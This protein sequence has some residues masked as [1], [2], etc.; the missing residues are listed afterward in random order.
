MEKH[1]WNNVLEIKNLNLYIRKK[2]L[3]KNI[4]LSIDNN[5][6]IGIIGYSKS[7][8]SLLLKCISK[9]V[10]LI[11]GCKIE[12]TIEINGKNIYNDFYPSSCYIIEKPYVFPCSISKNIVYSLKIINR[13][14]NKYVSIQIERYL[15]EVDLCDEVKNK[16]DMDAENLN[17][18]QKQKLC[19]ARG[20][21]TRPSLILADNPT[22]FFD[23]D[24]TMRFEELLLKLKKNYTIILVPKNINQARRICDEVIF[25]DNGTIIEKGPTTKLL[26]DPETEQLR[27]YIYIN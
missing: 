3:L 21:A 5:K 26:E 2:I 23:Y 16:L 12:G 8:K 25:I 27:K 15:K 1:T 4:D 14:D 17:F 18:F 22:L 10:S 19:L 11:D 20:L 7:G 13:K 6:I 24:S 9:F